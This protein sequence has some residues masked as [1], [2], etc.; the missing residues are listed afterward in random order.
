MIGVAP[1]EN[2]GLGFQ[3]AERPRMND[4]VAI[5]LKVVSVGMLGLRITPT[6]RLFNT[7]RVIS[8]HERR[9]V[10]KFQSFKVSKTW[11]LTLKLCN[12]ET[13]KLAFYGF[14]DCSLASRTF[15]DSSFFCT[16]AKLS[17]STSGATVLFHSAT[18]RSQ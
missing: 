11:N 17:V 7:N 14:S 8:E 9:I 13:L 16:L 5:A 1:S 15:A 3:T 10:S 4:A 12:T 6:A 2:L 18:A